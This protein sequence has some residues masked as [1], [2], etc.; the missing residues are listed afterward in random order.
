MQ[1]ETKV[2]ISGNLSLE[3]LEN[4]INTKENVERAKLVGLSKSDKPTV[5]DNVGIFVKAQLG[6][7]VPELLLRLVG[8]GQSTDDVKPE[9]TTELVF[10]S[11]VFVQ[12]AEQD[13]AGFR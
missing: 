9:N 12:G 4:S 13:V 11:V 10:H 2:S 5:K 7:D 3:D 6:V 1:S 8:D